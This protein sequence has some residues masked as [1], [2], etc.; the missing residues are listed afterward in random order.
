MK[1]LCIYP[2][3]DIRVNDNAYALTYLKEVGVDV[4]VIC[5]RMCGL[6][7]S[8]ERDRFEEM[9]GIPVHRVYADFAEQSS[10]PVR[11]Y[12]QVYQIARQFQPD[13]I[14]CSVQYNMFISNR[15]KSDLEVPVV[16]L[17]EFAYDPVRLLKRRWYLG[18][19]PLAHPIG[20]LYWRWL[21]KNSQAIITSYMGDEPHLSY[22]SRYGT[23]AYYIP[24]CNHI[25]AGVSTNNPERDSKRG[26]YVG[27]LS[28]WKNT[29]EL[30]VTLPRIL[31]RTPV[32]EFVVVGPG[33]GVGIVQKLKRR[34]GE[35][36]TYIPSLPRLEVLKLIQQ[37][38]FSYTPTKGRGW[39]F[40]GDSWGVRTP[41]IVTHNEYGFRD[42]VDALVVDRLD[43]IH[44][45]V[46]ELYEHPGLHQRL[47]EAGYERAMR[48]HSAKNVGDKL[49]HVFEAAM[50]LWRKYHVCQGV[51]SCPQTQFRS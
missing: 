3:M 49:L 19:K 5:S 8:E 32:R 36:I 34:Y 9:Q 24:W 37:S 1:V 4:A 38:Y 29:D 30:A 25:P 13:V 46:R 7:S 18:L 21:A 17:V 51:H 11:H 50:S 12:E 20:R 23:P 44:L 42:R 14:F 27:S 43:R 2:G 10:F 35:R 16:L 15:L 39:G 26:V 31:D 47:Q 6:K 28:K 45:A 33:P 40:I 48:D 41:L 22:L